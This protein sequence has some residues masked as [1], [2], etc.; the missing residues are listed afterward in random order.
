MEP[1]S[2]ETIVVP[3]GHQASDVIAGQTFLDLFGGR[4]SDLIDTAAT[5]RSTV[6]SIDRFFVSALTGSL[7][8]LSSSWPRSRALMVTDCDVEARLC[9]SYSFGA[10]FADDGDVHSLVFWALLR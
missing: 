8:L 1:L 5:L 2:I 4:L 7:S 9:R 10:G 3:G 6:S